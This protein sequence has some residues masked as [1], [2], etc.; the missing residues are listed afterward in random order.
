[1]KS[2]ILF[3]ACLTSSL[4]AR[5]GE[6]RDACVARYGQPTASAP[7]KEWDEF[8]KGGVKITVWYYQECADKIVYAKMDDSTLT[9]VGD[10][11]SGD[12][13]QILQ[14]NAAGYTWV[15]VKGAL[16]LTYDY[17]TERRWLLAG[18][19]NLTGKITLVTVDH[20]Q[21]ERDKSNSP[22]VDLEGF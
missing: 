5:V 16:A 2:L 9:G 21:R 18:K 8:E 1:M 19:S 20:V 14:A 4:F 7:A 11:T 12:F 6:S 22:S 15:K 10:F 17:A 3:F 13:A